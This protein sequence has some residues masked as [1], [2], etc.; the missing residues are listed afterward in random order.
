MEGKRE[1]RQSKEDEPQTLSQSLY[2]W[3][4][5]VAPVIIG[6][7]LVFTFVGRLTPVDGDSM[8]PT[9]HDR[10][11]LVVRGLGYTP[12]NG[13]IVVLTKYFENIQGPIVKRIIA[14]GG[15]TVQIDYE[16]GTVTVDGQVLEEDYIKEDMIRQ[17]WQQIDTITV[18]EGFVFV[19]G[20]NRNISNDSRNPALGAV[21]VRYI[22]G[23]VAF[24]I[25]ALNF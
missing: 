20:D 13:D 15:Q 2:G 14:V 17:S 23:E 8:Y 5:A 16:A 21:D 6:I 25:P 1:R 7:I 12:E 3:L 10:D 24:T 9:L 11:M 19:M 4:Q 18:P 22:L